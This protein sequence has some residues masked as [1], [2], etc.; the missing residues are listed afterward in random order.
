M[1]K[2]LLLLLFI[3]TSSTLLAQDIDRVKV[4]GKINAT[5]GDDL[6]G[7]NVYNISSQKGTI[8]DA[9][10]EFEIEIA[11]NDRLTITALQYQSFTVIVDKGIIV[12]R[13]MNIYLNPAVN[14]LEEVVVRPYDLS[15]NINADVKKIHT[16]SVTNDW[17][18]SYENMEYGYNFAPDVQTKIQGNAAEESLN[19][20]NLTN[21][22]NIKNLFKGA[23]GLLF[24]EKEKISPAED[25]MK[26]N[27]LNK[28]LRQRFSKEFITSTFGISEKE[29]VDFLYFAQED[30]LDRKLLK[31]ENEM[32]LMDFLFKKSETYKKRG[33]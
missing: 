7:I 33:E 6:E 27:E 3:I 16:Y 11:A 10:G 5:A 32:Q 12:Q 28:N 8:T 25:L 30:G 23:I 13:K 29:A 24:P 22:L 1:A 20:H 18:L 31:P 15:G 14:Q 21:G 26:G 19:E 4:S 17:D 9:D 2:K